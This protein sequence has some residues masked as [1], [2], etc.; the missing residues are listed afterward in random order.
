MSELKKRSMISVLL[1]LMTVLA[2]GL[3]LIPQQAKGQEVSPD[4]SITAVGDVMLG[5]NVDKKITAKGTDYPF[6][7]LDGRLAAAD[8]TFGNLE[9]PLSDE[10]KAL[11][12]KSVVFRGDLAMAAVLRQQ[13]FDIMSL[14]NNHAMDY[15]SE[16]LIETITLLS[17]NGIKSVGAGSDLQ[18]ARKAVIIT[19][20]GL[21]VGFLAYTDK[22]YTDLFIKKS[23][24][25]D[26]NKCG[27][28]PLDEEMIMEDLAALETQVDITVVSLHWGKEYKDKPTSSDQKLAH[29]IIDGGAELI[30]GHHP[31]RIQGVERYKNG[32]IAY[33]LGNFIF[34]QKSMLYMRQSMILDVKLAEQQVIEASITP[35]LISDCQPAILTGSKAA[36]LLKKIAG[37]CSKLDTTTL[38]QNDKL[39]INMN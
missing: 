11:Y 38:I 30:L 28:T 23:F 24:A 36:T 12:G 26:D 2:G 9:S 10:G 14:A 7:L 5:R 39:I 29:D 13:G 15:N 6:R 34:D 8:I 35:V 22:Y 18:E 25:A 16:A 21:R 31:H 27:V 20:N 33:S 37:Y 32:L 4:I 1:I 3:C 19:K 17:E